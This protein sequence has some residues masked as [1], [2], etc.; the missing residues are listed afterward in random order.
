V[1]VNKLGY[2][3]TL[4]L[5]PGLRLRV[6]SH[7]VRKTGLCRPANAATQSLLGCNAQ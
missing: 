1:V 6:F 4:A 3:Q 5:F 7:T 2:S